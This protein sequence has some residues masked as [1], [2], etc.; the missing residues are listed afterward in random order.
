MAGL[1]CGVRC[2]IETTTTLGPGPVVV[3]NATSA[4]LLYFR[5]AE[6][7]RRPRY[8]LNGLC[9]QFWAPYCT[10]GGQLC[11]DTVIAL[12]GHTIAWTMTGADF[13][14]QLNPWYDDAMHYVTFERD[15]RNIA[16]VE[17][18]TPV[19][20]SY[21]GIGLNFRVVPLP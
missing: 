4:G 11:E 21:L 8:A 15:R 3:L 18:A 10:P 5:G 2:T 16:H 6:D 14:D 17:Y 19:G 1:T 13:L 12:Q 20:N 7:C 9:S